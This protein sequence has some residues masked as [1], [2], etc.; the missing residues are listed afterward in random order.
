[1]FPYYFFSLLKG[2]VIL[3]KKV[4]KPEKTLPDTL[5]YKTSFF[6]DTFLWVFGILIIIYAIK[7][8]LL[9]LLPYMVIQGMEIQ[10]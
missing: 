8:N 5:H 3:K 4:K 1:M 2:N 10:D 6:C 9:E 7:H